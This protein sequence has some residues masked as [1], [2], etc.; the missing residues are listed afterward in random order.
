MCDWI[1]I[2]VSLSIFGLVLSIFNQQA[3]H[4][5]KKICSRYRQR[6]IAHRI[7]S[8]IFDRVFRKDCTD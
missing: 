3:N 2:V 7:E 1:L 5:T 8:H 6:A 4:E